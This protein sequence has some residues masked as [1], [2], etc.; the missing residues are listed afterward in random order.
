MVNYLSE[1]KPV[2]RAMWPRS[3]RGIMFTV[4]GVNGG[5]D[6]WSKISKDPQ[7]KR[8]SVRAGGLNVGYGLC[9]RSCFLRNRFGE[10]GLA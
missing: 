6:N 7:R 8:K 9:R 2:T 4:E 3:P 5:H 1:G 10:E